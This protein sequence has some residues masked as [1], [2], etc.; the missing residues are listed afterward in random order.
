MNNA[1]WAGGKWELCLCGVLC[2]TPPYPIASRR[3]RPLRNG[4]NDAL[5]T[6][7]DLV[8]HLDYDVENI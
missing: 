5:Q 7:V 3:L 4:K 6:A 8:Q 2:I 1:T